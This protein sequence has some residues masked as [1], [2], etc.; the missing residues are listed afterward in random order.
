ML[1]IIKLQNLFHPVKATVDAGDKVKKLL[2]FNKSKD[3]PLETWDIYYANDKNSDFPRALIKFDKPKIIINE[4]ITSLIL[5]HLYPQVTPK[6]HFIKNKQ[7]IGI[8]K[9][10]QG[11][12][13]PWS[14]N[15]NIVYD[16]ISYLPEILAAS[17]LLADTT[18]SKRHIILEKDQGEKNYKGYRVKH[19]KSLEYAH[20]I[21][22]GP[23]V[24]QN[25][26]IRENLAL[27]GISLE[28]LKSDA[29]LTQLRYL[30]HYNI[31][32]LESSI[33]NGYEDIN[34]YFNNIKE[35]TK[36][37]SSEQLYIKAISNFLESR[38]LVLI[39]LYLELKLQKFIIARD[40][41]AIE[42]IL[43]NNRGLLFSNINWFFDPYNVGIP[44]NNSMTIVEYIN[45][46]RL[47]DE[48]VNLKLTK[49]HY[50]LVAEY[51]TTHFESMDSMNITLGSV[52]ETI[53]NMLMIFNNYNFEESIY[54]LYKDDLIEMI[55]NII[56]EHNISNKH[57]T[58]SQLAKKLTGLYYDFIVNKTMQPS[59]PQ[60]HQPMAL[61]CH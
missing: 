3:K 53:Q 7:K 46:F 2:S 40:Y 60:Q 23:G 4:Y 16:K 30:L 14:E 15:H 12:M 52:E 28:M 21:S 44:Y 41:N 50:R 22:N 57:K 37:F 51:I 33:K 6:F 43:Q 34:L 11:N 32:E 25:Y 27:M 61:D 5:N 42:K 20:L 35:K 36:F 18:I 59:L 1:S 9:E 24:D 19:S 55:A 47:V 17:I 29:F 56:D 58:I 38:K 26:Y 48:N 10:Y 49:L 45:N 8:V 31:S 39:K 54:Y 13:I